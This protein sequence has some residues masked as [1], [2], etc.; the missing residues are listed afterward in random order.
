MPDFGMTRQAR[1]TAKL[2]R[3]FE[4]LGVPCRYYPVG[5]DPELP[6]TRL[7]NIEGSTG[8]S[9]AYASNEYV[10]EKILMVQFLLQQGEVNADDQF[11]PYRMNAAGEY[12]LTGKRYRLTAL[13]QIDDISATWVYLD[14]T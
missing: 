6:E 3:L 2:L 14:V 9:A 12:E 8:L 7:V 10:P 4:R 11:E 13:S 1:Q 5:G